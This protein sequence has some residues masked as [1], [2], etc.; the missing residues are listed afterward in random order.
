M[1]PKLSIV[2]P[3]YN[4]SKILSDNLPGILHEAKK[5]SIPIYIS[6]NSLNDKTKKLVLKL[7][8]SYE[9]LFYE[10]NLTDVGHDKNSLHS[11]CLPKSDYVWLLG[12]SFEVFTSAFKMLIN[13]IEKYKP[14]LI[15]VNSAGRELDYKSG[16]YDHV[17]VFRNLGWHLTLT[18]VT[19]YSRD[20]IK[21][22]VRNEIL[23]SKNFPQIPLI[24]NYLSNDKGLYWI[25]NKL[26]KASNKKKGYW[27]SSTFSIFIDDWSRAILSISNCYSDEDKQDVILQHSHKTNIFGFKSMV[28]IRLNK[29]FNYKILFR[30]KNQ[31]I[32]HS[33]LNYLTLFLIAVSPVPVLRI[34]RNTIF[35]FL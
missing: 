14:N 18:G 34:V 33:N 20:A 2:I 8:S 4:R 13:I 7:S 26:I 28:S 23:K 6:D 21:S 12:D 3:T 30:Y 29:A 10:K 27:V 16:V 24:F 25:N 35:K 1:F 15:S 19:I 22:M 9:F 31:L 5:Y 11:L 32:R 17:E